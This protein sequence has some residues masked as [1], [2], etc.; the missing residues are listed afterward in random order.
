MKI[1]KTIGGEREKAISESERLKSRKKEEKR[2]KFSIAIFFILLLLVVVVIAGIAVT[3]LHE[4]KKSETAP[5]K[6]ETYAPTV[7]I[8]DEGGTGYITDRI[9]NYVGM[10]EVDFKDLGYTVEKAIV[11]AGKTREVDIYLAGR[12]EFYK[13]HL[14]RSTSET[15][16][17]ATRMI[18][19]LD[20]KGKAV[21]YVDIRISG[22][23]YYK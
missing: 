13:C 7:E 19:Y 18:K 5:V 20:E 14:D 8:V 1:G 21:S 4:R 23:A 12:K 22:R 16:E 6:T 9:K 2:K 11:P 15:A 17:D 3:A 10:I